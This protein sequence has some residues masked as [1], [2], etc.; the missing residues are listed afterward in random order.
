ML[1]AFAIC[2]KISIVD[3]SEPNAEYKISWDG[4]SHHLTDALKYMRKYAIFS[5]VTIFCDEQKQFRAHRNILS[6]CSSV[7]RTLLESS[8]GYSDP[9]IYLRGI[10]HEE[11]ESILQFIYNGQTTLN[12]SKINEFLEVA[13][14]LDIEDLVSEYFPYEED[15]NDT[16]QMNIIKHESIE[17]QKLDEERSITTDS[18]KD[19]SQEENNSNGGENRWKEGM[20]IYKC[21]HCD[22]ET[23]KKSVLKVHNEAKHEGVKYPCGQCGSELKNR[24]DLSRHIKSIHQGIKH[25]CVKCG[26]LFTQ[27]NAMKQHMKKICNG[28]GYKCD[29]C[30]YKDFLKANTLLHMESNHQGAKYSC[31]QCSS[32]L[33][34]KRALQIHIESVHN[35]FRYD[36]S[37]CGKQFTQKYPMKK[38]MKTCEKLV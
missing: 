29:F 32:K 35:G 22:Y 5:D 16:T 13:K 23:A 33:F 38:H 6:S 11:M 15:N 36:C 20:Q 28:L 10:K 37:M 7:F 30:D 27:K 2:Y 34:S 9:I 21:T 4:Y 31:D 1:N 3:M 14:S 26:K 25:K 19:E 24:G 12:V 17:N 18:Y 8:V